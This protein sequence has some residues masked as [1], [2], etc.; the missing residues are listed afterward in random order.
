M[1]SKNL[2]FLGLALFFVVNVMYSAMIGMDLS[3]FL[4]GIIGSTI[5]GQNW[6]VLIAFIVM[7]VLV[8]NFTSSVLTMLTLG[9]LYYKFGA[10][11]NPILL[12]P[13]YR[14]E[15]NHIKGLFVSVIVLITVLTLRMFLSPDQMSYGIFEWMKNIPNEVSK[16]GNF[17][18]YGVIFGLMT[19]IFHMITPENQTIEKLKVPS[20]PDKFKF[21]FRN[22]F[23]VLMGIVLLYFI[24]FFFGGIGLRI[25]GFDNGIYHWFSGFANNRI[26][27][28]NVF[29]FIASLIVMGLSSRLRKLETNKDTYSQLSNI[30]IVF[31]VFLVAWIGICA[32]SR[33]TTKS[34][35]GEY[36]VQNI[37]ITI[38]SFVLMFTLSGISADPKN[39]SRMYNK[40]FELID[41]TNK[42]E[43]YIF[44]KVVVA[45]LMLFPLWS[46]IGM[47]SSYRNE[48]NNTYGIW[49]IIKCVFT[50]MSNGFTMNLIELFNIIK[51]LLIVV[52]FVFTGYTIDEYRKTIAG[53]N[54]YNMYRNKFNFDATFGVCMSFLLLALTTSSLT[55]DNFPK[56]LTMIIEYLAPIAILIMAS[57]LVYYANDMAKLSRQEVLNDVQKEKKR[58]RELADNSDINAPIATSKTYTGTTPKI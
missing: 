40:V 22:L 11:G 36:Y 50:N 9:N 43:S 23:Y 26:P 49:E 17:M 6:T 33:L 14:V 45:L 44:S 55:T 41:V 10:K 52:A 42:S 3:A 1:F 8:L 54:K 28:F 39:P 7:V 29:V 46:F 38:I 58:Q 12:S 56:L 30:G 32:F 2:E 57:Y 35:F 5:S 34:I 20:F 4:T 18:L 37:G 19:T 27:G 24:P 48:C 13:E 21:H 51:G 15:L 25:L 47:V 31:S 16:Y 53:S